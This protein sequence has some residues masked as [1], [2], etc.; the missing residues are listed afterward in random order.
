MS[1]SMTSKCPVNPTQNGMLG[2]NRVAPHL[3]QYFF[4]SLRA[5]PMPGQLEL[6]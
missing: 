3:T 6:H 4:V 2:L 5:L 1:F